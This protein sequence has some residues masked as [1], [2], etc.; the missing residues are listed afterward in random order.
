M[1]WLPLLLTD[2]SPCLRYLVL[3][4]LMKKDGKE[5][6]E[7][8]NDRLKDTLVQE[9]IQLQ[10]SDGSWGKGS[11]PT[12]ASTSK[13]QLTSQALTRL[14]YLGFDSEFEPVN[15]GAEYLFT[16][17]EEDG[18]WPLGNYSTDAEGRENYD[19]M[20]LQTSI[21][22]RGLAECKYGAS[23]RAEKAYEWLLDQ[24]LDDGSWPT[25]IAH[26]N[27][28]YVAGY[29]RLPHSRWGCRS[30]TTS[31]LICLSL[32]PF[33]R[34]GDE[35]QKAFDLL[36]GIEAR[37]RQHLG[38]DI[39]RTMGYEMSRG[40]L[41]YYARYDM[42][43]TLSL[44]SRIGASVSDSRI[45]ELLDHVDTLKGRYGLWEYLPNPRAS[46]WV[47]YD[48]LLSLSTIDEATDWVSLEPRTPFQ[49]YST[50]RRRY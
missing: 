22:L 18:S 34:H 44:C 5:T 8:K 50:K 37:E 23:K 42:A 1:T 28:G 35:S 13:I 36:L 38:Y 30:N 39:A 24:R 12:T 29:R 10:N 45:A 26:G 17:Q 7:L 48:L 6:K 21:P 40:F 25:G 20:S 3:K 31:A 43:Q 27:Y 46:R 2:E 19:S 14:G 9:L 49:K 33:R 11:L 47:T 32:H 16:H 15:N 41:T 4:K